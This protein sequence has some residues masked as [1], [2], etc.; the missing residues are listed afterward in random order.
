MITNK[1]IEV[2]DVVLEIYGYVFL[3][4]NEGQMQNISFIRNTNRHSD[5]LIYIHQL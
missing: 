5:I 4:V 2:C 3:N 1:T